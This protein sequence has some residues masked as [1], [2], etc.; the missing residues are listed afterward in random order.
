[1]LIFF[2]IALLYYIYFLLISWKLY[3]CL[4]LF[5]LDIISFLSIP[6]LI[7]TFTLFTERSLEFFD[8][9]TPNHCPPNLSVLFSVSIIFDICRPSSGIAGSH[10]FLKT[11]KLFSEV[12]TPFYNPTS[13]VGGSSFSTFSPTLSLSCLS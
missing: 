1:M 7:G 11:A 10:R 2:W 12:A 3:T 4:L 8:S 5:N 13:N 9:V 6:L